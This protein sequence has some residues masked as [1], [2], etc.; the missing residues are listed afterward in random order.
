MGDSVITR[1]TLVEKLRDHQIRNHN[2]WSLLGLF[3][4]RPY[5]STWVEVIVALLWAFIFTMFMLS[6]Y[7]VYYLN[8]NWIALVIFFIGILIPIRLRSA[9][10]YLTRRGDARMQLPLSM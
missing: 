5:I 3:S 1:S 2:K 9:R 4:H 10:K 7:L 6:S 8:H